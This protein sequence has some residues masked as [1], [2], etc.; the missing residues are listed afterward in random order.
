[1]RNRVLGVI[2]DA[3][4]SGTYR[5]G[6]RLPSER[7]LASD[8]GVSRAI[9]GFAI[10]ELAQRGVLE[11]RRGRG[12][13]TFVVSISDLPSFGERTPGDRCDV[14]NWLLEVREPIELAAALLVSARARVADLRALRGIYAE[15]SESIDDDTEYAEASMR[16]VLKLAEASGNPLLRNVVGQLVNEQ[17]TLRREFSAFEEPETL[18]DL[19]RASLATHAELLTAL[20]GGDSN[21]IAMAVDTHMKNIRAIYLGDDRSAQHFTQTLLDSP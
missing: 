20:E 19:R 1:M 16:F 8:I 11:S 2:I 7:E 3:L 13:G 18:R 6:D 5:E 21:E 14:M 9:V 10:D 17:A 15:M 4:R 12:G